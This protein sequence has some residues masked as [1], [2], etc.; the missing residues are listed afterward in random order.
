[1]LSDGLSRQVKYGYSE[2]ESVHRV[3]LD[4][5]GAQS[6]GTVSLGG[7]FMREACQDIVL[8][9][10]DLEPPEPLERA[11]DSLAVLK[12]NQ[13]LRMIIG[14]E[15]FPLY[16]MLHKRGYLRET[17]VRADGDYEILVWRES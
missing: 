1:M 2:D 15:P 3:W 16:D 10:R 6:V 5:T 8:D 7:G 9:V 12:N 13:R 14:R 17:V 4:L 11:L